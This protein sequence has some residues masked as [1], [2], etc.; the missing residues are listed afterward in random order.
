MVGA[1]WGWWWR[2]ELSRLRYWL[3]SV[4]LSIYENLCV[5]MKIYDYLCMFMNIYDYL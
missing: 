4:F 2:G 1:G 5:F 3:D